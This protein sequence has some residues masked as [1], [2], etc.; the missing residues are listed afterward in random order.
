MW[1]IKKINS[2]FDDNEDYLNVFPIE[3]LM[4]GIDENEPNKEEAIE[5]HRINCKQCF[6][7]I[8]NE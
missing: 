4:I 1:N 2:L 7:D 5:A 6:E 3:I 8:I